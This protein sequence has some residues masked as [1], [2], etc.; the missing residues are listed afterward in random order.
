MRRVDEIAQE[1]LS[2]VSSDAGRGLVVSWVNARY[3]ELIT[4]VRFRHTR[5][6]GE[7]QMPAPVTTGTVTLVAGASVVTGDTT[8]RAAWATLTSVEGYHFRGAIVWYRVVGLTPDSDL[9]LASPFTETDLAAGSSYVLAL[10][11][12]ELDLRA[13]NPEFFVHM[14]RHYTFRPIAPEFLDS[15]AP[16]RPDTTSGP[17]Y[18]TIVGSGVNGGVR[19]ELYPLSTQAETLHYVYRELPVRLRATDTLPAVI[20][21]YIL[22]EGVLIDIMRWEQA[23]AAHAGQVE[24]AALWRN[25]AR[26]QETRWRE[27]VNQAILQDR[28]PDDLTFV[29][30]T[31]A[32]Y[33]GAFGPRDITSASDHV[34]SR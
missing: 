34:W 23:K 6:V 30:Q 26:A 15:F 8:A 4:K 27:M 20:D 5:R 13:R 21:G 31:A 12:H 25:D 17:R 22:K 14:R 29:T 7:L 16:E 32:G 9:M 11:E 33:G 24:A 18:A 3:L 1:A 2:A 19:I 28:G 10:R